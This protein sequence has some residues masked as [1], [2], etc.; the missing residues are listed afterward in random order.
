MRALLSALVLTLLAPVAHAQTATGPEVLVDQLT[1]DDQ[2]PP[3]QYQTLLDAAIAER[4]APIRTCYERRLAARSG[5]AGEVRLRLWVSARQVI[6]ATQESTTLADTELETCARDEVRRFTLPP[7]APEGGAAVRFRISFRVPAGWAPRAGTS[8]SST[9]GEAATVPTI[10]PVVTPLPEGMV[11]PLARVSLSWRVD[12]ASGGLTAEEL[13]ASTLGQELGRCVAPTTTAVGELP[14]RLT[15]RRTGVTRY[16]TGRGT[17]RDR[18]MIRCL[19]TAVTAMR[20]EPRPRS[21]TARI[22][23]TLSALAR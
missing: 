9:T 11:V 1:V 8:S 5:L 22:T 13:T 17:L 18:V 3:S 7:Q 14:L 19:Q 2:V 4:V 16:S 6:R 20:F 10:P 21:T 12:S 15:I 23:V